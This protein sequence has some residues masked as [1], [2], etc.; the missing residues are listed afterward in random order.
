MIPDHAVS[1]ELIDR[2]RARSSATLHEAAKKSGALPAAIKPLSPEVCLCG[3]A[4]P[5][6]SPSGDNLWLHHA[7]YAADPG[8]V[9]VVDVGA[10]PEF[11][12]WGEV[13]ALAAQSRGLSGLVING[14]VRDA[15]RLVA[16][17]FPVF[18][19]T[20]C[21]R[22]TSKN[23]FGKGS[24]GAPITVGAVNIVRGDLVFGDG[25]GVVVLPAASAAAIVAEGEQR[26]AGEAE[27]F[28][29]L[30]AGETTLAI[31]GLPL[32][33]GAHVPA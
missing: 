17:K 22:G 2:A 24:L 15:Q 3:R 30:R 32:P 33:A 7:I 28:R 10:D 11:G 1:D 20:N 9:L 26:D 25:D 29:R 16:M 19:W 21:I 31:Y 5:V 13:M 14:G 6:G 8:D 18:A 12:Y 4:Y 27:I 23:P